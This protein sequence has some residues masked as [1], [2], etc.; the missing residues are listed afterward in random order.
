M[1]KLVATHLKYF[2]SVIQ[3]SYHNYSIL[4]NS[5][6][7]HLIIKLMKNYKSNKELLLI[8]SGLFTE[9][10]ITNIPV[11]TMKEFIGELKAS[12]K[13]PNESKE[14]ISTI[15]DSILQMIKY[16]SPKEIF[17]FSGGSQSGIGIVTRKSLPK[18]GYSFFGWIRLERKRLKNQEEDIR[19]IF[20][21][22]SGKDKEIELSVKNNCICY[23][24]ADGKS[25]DSPYKINF[26]KK[27]LVEDVW[28]FI[29][30]YH[31]NSDSPK[32]VVR[33]KFNLLDIIC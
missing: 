31:I 30:L 6:T 12:Y 3:S 22:A 17:C 16:K 28:Y 32:S 5:S 23:S 33:V 25:K 18:E 27:K 8:I 20:Q 19:R 29:E 10:A 7:F 15:L 2:S 9:T 26:S 13:Y 11:E 4:A 24:V 21:L 1:N 14:Y